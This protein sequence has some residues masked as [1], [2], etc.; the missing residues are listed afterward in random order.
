MEQF[1]VHLLVSSHNT[2]SPHLR[3]LTRLQLVGDFGSFRPSD[4]ISTRFFLEDTKN[5]KK[6]GPIFLK[7][8]NMRDP[9]VG[10]QKFSRILKPEWSFDDCTYFKLGNCGNSVFFWQ[11]FFSRNQ[12]VWWEFFESFW[13]PDL[14]W[15]C[16]L[17][18]RRCLFELM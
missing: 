5:K 10:Q 2:S 16:R 12:R 11:C 13:F 15:A 3:N 6:I 17:L 1:F 8:M 4:K 18:F 9:L 14:F 7:F